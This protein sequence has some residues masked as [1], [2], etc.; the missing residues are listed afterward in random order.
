MSILYNDNI[1]KEHCDVMKINV[2]LYVKNRSLQLYV[3]IIL[4]FFRKTIS[5]NLFLHNTTVKIKY[6][7]FRIC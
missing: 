2:S 1:S 5:G 6:L 4:A 7:K 3:N